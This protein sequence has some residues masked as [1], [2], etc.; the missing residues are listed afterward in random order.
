[1]KSSHER[2]YWG[3]QLFQQ[4]IAHG[5][6]E[7]LPA[8]FGPNLMRCLMNQMALG[9]R[10]LN[11]AATQCL[12]AIVS[13]ATDDKA[14]IQ[15]MVSAILE[16]SVNFD[17]AARSKVVE[18]LLAE[19]DL[20]GVESLIGVIR[21][22]MELKKTSPQ[23][24]LSLADYL[25][26]IVR[27]HD[28]P[29]HGP[30]QKRFRAAI[31]SALD[32]LV[33]L[34]F[35]GANEDTNAAAMRARVTS[36]LNHVI[37]KDTVDPAYHPYHTLQSIKS[38]GIRLDADDAVAAIIAK[39]H[40]TL[41]K[42]V[43]KSEKADEKDVLHAFKLLF[44]F[45]LLQ[46]Y[47]GEA[48]AV[49][50]VDE[51]QDCFRSLD[52]KSHV[53]NYDE[54]VVALVEVIIDFVSKQSALYRRLAPKILASITDRIPVEGL[55]ALLGVLETKEDMQGQD[56]LF[57][58]A[59]EDELDVE[60]ADGP[61]E[62]S[63]IE[64][65]SADD[66][67]TASDSETSG[68]D[69]AD[70]SSEEADA[71]EAAELAEFDAKLANALGTRRADD[72]VAVNASESEDSDMDDAQMEGLDE[73]LGNMFKHRMGGGGKGSTARKDRKRARDTIVNF[74]TKV[75]ELLEVYV[76]QEHRNPRALHIVAPLLRAMQATSSSQIS[77]KIGDLVR[78]FS[79]LY[80]AKRSVADMGDARQHAS[81]ATQLLQEVHTIVGNTTSQLQ[82]KAC[83]SASL[84]A[85]KA[86]LS[87]EAPVDDA[88]KAYERTL[89]SLK[90]DGAF[91]FRQCFA[92]DWRNWL[93]QAAKTNILQA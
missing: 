85:V 89:G 12:Q 55:D 32:A 62:D 45:A 34:S 58:T 87:Y 86:M 56:E 66:G 7:F 20:D 76:K 79:K 5:N 78:H 30:E 24:V 71:A 51:L 39:G 16:Y 77:Q 21:G 83:S 53:A 22:Q 47:Y 4:Y 41:D 65:G 14:S 8:I 37:T 11:T 9:D 81:A 68:E 23:D 26:S 60:M 10:L 88:A 44:T 91:K 74:K 80:K 73:Q 6:V 2:R 90:T 38:R 42:I 36:C 93:A 84:L 31:N 25:V 67:S 59:A 46:A 52:K 29:Q 49:N 92:E 82:A 17:R 18:K 61:H 1:M 40:E 19:A 72:D 75:L 50:V 57:S 43:R 69:K 35:K 15:P 54:N 63:D 64:E 70:S 27:T 28:L 33:D 48:D 3:L 13:R